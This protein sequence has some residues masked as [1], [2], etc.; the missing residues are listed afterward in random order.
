METAVEDE[1]DDEK[2]REGI[3]CCLGKGKRD[4]KS[5]RQGG[6]EKEGTERPDWSGSSRVF[7]EHDGT[8]TGTRRT[9]MPSTVLLSL[10]SVAEWTQALTSNNQL[11]PP[12]TFTCFMSFRLRYEFN[13]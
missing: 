13:E 8:E 3:E 10:R 9:D 1:D 11:G 5:V 2:R 7:D 6:V 4:G 12:F